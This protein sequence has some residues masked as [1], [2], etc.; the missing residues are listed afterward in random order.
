MRLSCKSS[1]L[2]LIRP[3]IGQRIDTVEVWGSSPHVPTMLFVIKSL[4]A[5]DLHSPSAFV[6]CLCA[7]G[8]LHRCVS[9]C[10]TEFM[11]RRRFENGGR[12]VGVARLGGADDSLVAA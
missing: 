8:W 2:L 10:V 12:S 4:I 9:M 5:G 3:Y 6:F 7:L 11:K 1:S